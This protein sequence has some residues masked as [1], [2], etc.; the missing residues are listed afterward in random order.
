MISS[1]DFAVFSWGRWRISTA[2][3]PQEGPTPR[4]AVRQTDFVSSRSRDRQ[5][6][7]LLA[8]TGQLN[9]RLPWPLSFLSRRLTL[10]VALLAVLA[11]PTSRQLSRRILLSVCLAFGWITLLWWAPLPV[12]EIGRAILLLAAL[13][14]AL[15]GGWVAGGPWRSRL[16]RLVPRCAVVDAYPPVLVLCTGWVLYPW[17]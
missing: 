2:T 10:A 6:A 16:R 3:A 15:G 4:E 12:G 17:L 14:G 7:T 8:A 13:V 9:D 5:R 11:V 1:A